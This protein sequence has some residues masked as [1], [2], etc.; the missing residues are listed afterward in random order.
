MI[1]TI[2]IIGDLEKLLTRRPDQDHPFS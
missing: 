2:T 1:N